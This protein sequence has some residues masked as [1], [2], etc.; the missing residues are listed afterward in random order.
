MQIKWI[1]FSCEEVSH[2]QQVPRYFNVKLKRFLTTVEVHIPRLCLVLTCS[3]KSQLQVSRKGSALSFQKMSESTLL[4]S[5]TNHKQKTIFG[6]ILWQK[7]AY[8]SRFQD[9]WEWVLPVSRREILR[10][11]IHLY[12]CWKYSV[13]ISG[14]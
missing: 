10:K 8:P 2:K 4:H 1:T 3:L 13:K 6:A 14:S 9:L 5:N 12:S 11:S 7:L